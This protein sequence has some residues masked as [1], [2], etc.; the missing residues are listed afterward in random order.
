MVGDVIV[1]KGSAL[2]PGAL[3]QRVVRANTVVFLVPPAY[4][5]EALL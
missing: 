3:G 2:A 1:G 5:F 4:R